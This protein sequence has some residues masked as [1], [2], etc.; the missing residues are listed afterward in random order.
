MSTTEEKFNFWV[1]AQA[2]VV[3]GGKS[4]ADSD[5]RRW[6]QGI[7][8][9]ESRDLQGEV[10][11]QK[12]IDF[13]YFLKH[14]YLN[15]DHKPGNE[16]KVGEPTECRLTKDGLWVKGFLYPD[17]KT[18]ND[19]WT[20]MTNLT[21]SGSSRRMGFSIEGRVV[22]RNGRTIEKC[23]IQDVAVTPSPVNATTWAEM[24]KSLS[25]F[26]WDTDKEE[27]ALSSSNVTVPESLDH[28][29]K[30]EAM[31]SL[32]YDETVVFIENYLGISKGSAETLATFA[33]KHL[34]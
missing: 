22:K 21:K 9:T 23:W 11:A 12:G 27:K 1:P 3:K 17:K 5:G 30:D 24:A 8:S 31:K 10:V 28:E 4:G 33:F 15:N 20:H 2:V 13:S 14:G 6:I 16:N 19:I 32:T 29:E 7:A 26:S 25:G 18:S 34:V